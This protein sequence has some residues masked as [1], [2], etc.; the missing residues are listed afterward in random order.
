[1]KPT[2][3]QLKKVMSHLSSLRMTK[4]TA[5]RRK[6]IARLAVKARWAKRREFDNK[7]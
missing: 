7:V 1:M 6:E 3:E 5:E 2:K 4:M